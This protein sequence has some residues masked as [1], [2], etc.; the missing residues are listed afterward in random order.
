M[1]ALSTFKY[2]YESN[3]IAIYIY[4]FSVQLNDFKLLIIYENNVE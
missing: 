2:L 1:L 3:K 4:I